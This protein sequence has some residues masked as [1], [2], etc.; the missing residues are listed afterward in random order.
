MNQHSRIESFTRRQVRAQESLFKPE[1]SD[2][3][4]DD[5]KGANWDYFMATVY[6]FGA[7][8]AL[9]VVMVFGWILW[10]LVSWP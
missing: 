3:P 7:G 10:D 2:W 6:G 5:D 9:M 4:V 1:A 8:I